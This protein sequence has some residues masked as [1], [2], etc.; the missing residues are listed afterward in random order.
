MSIDRGM[1]KEAVV[2]THTE[3][4]SAIRKNKAMWCIH[5]HTHTHTEYYSV[6][7]KNKA[8]WNTHTHTYT[9]L[10]SHKKE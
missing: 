9:Q 1:D 4:Y 10:L 2:Y 8:M 7:R 3:Y 5:T 6:I